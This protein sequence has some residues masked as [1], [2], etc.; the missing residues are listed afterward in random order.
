MD[1]NIS[2]ICLDPPNALDR[3][4]SG[5]CSFDSNKERPVQESQ[6]NLMSKNDLANLPSN[7]LDAKQHHRSVFDTKV[8]VA[9]FHNDIT[10]FQSKTT[11]NSSSKNFHSIVKLLSDTENEWFDKQKQFSTAKS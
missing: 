6:L 7:N 4:A 11:Q 3:Q 9:K 8:S 10:L 5:G 1:F 2:S